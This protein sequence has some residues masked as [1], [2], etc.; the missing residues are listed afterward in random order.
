MTE[1]EK[2]KIG[3]ACAYSPLPLIDAAGFVPYRI[4]PLSDAPDQAGTLLHDNLCPHVK[5]LLDRAMS[6]DLPALAG[7]VFMNSCDAMRRL[8]DGWSKARPE[9]NIA[10]LDLPIGN[11]R[12]S[13]DYFEK[14]LSRLSIL[15]EQWGGQKASNTRLKKSIAAYNDLANAL[16]GLKKLSSAGR[17]A[18]GAAKLQKV[19]NKSVTAPIDQTMPE[20]ENLKSAVNPSESEKTHVPVFLFGNVLPDFAAFELFETCGVALVADDLCTGSRQISPIDNPEETEALNDLARGLLA[21]PPCAR[22]MPNLQAGEIIDRVVAQAKECGARGVIAHIMKFC[23]PYL[24]RLPAIQQELR[25]QDIPLLV[26]EGDCTL[27]S[28]GQQRTRIEAFVEMLGGN[29]S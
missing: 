21:R 29:P 28:L 16:D 2:T 20:I 7:V 12:P 11:N 15:L 24:A 14:E 6:N 10:L 23:D 26:L 9:E 27:R 19:F 3:F 4:L 22:T 18:G 17:L 1:K 25:K 5:R 8:A 13:Q